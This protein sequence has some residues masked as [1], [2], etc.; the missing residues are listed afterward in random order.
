[1]EPYHFAYSCPYRRIFIQSFRVLKKALRFFDYDNW[2]FRE[3][4][5][6]LITENGKYNHRIFVEA[7]SWE[8]ALYVIAFELSIS[9]KKENVFIVTDGKV[10]S[11]E[12]YPFDDN[13]IYVLDYDISENSIPDDFP[14]LLIIPKSKFMRGG[15]RS[16]ETVS[17]PPRSTRNLITALQNSGVGEARELIRKN[18]QSFESL[19]NYFCREFEYIDLFK[20]T[21]LDEL[22]TVS[23]LSLFNSFEYK[24]FQFVADFLGTSVGKLN[25]ILLKYTIGKDKFLEI[26]K[27]FN[28]SRNLIE[29]V[30]VVQNPI[31]LNLW[32]LSIADEATIDS[33]YDFSVKLLNIFPDRETCHLFGETECSNS[34]IKGILYTWI[35]L[36]EIEDYYIYRKCESFVEA[37]IN[38]PKLNVSY[39]LK[40]LTRIN[41]RCAYSI[42]VT[43]IKSRTDLSDPQEIRYIWF[44]WKDSLQLIADYFDTKILFSL[45]DDVLPI[46]QEKNCQGLLLSFFIDELDPWRDVTLLKLEDISAFLTIHDNDKNI[47]DMAVEFLPNFYRG[48]YSAKPS[49]GIEYDGI[50]PKYYRLEDRER[51]C[52]VSAYVQ[53]AASYRNKTYSDL[54]KIFYRILSFDTSKFDLLFQNFEL[55]SDEEKIQIEI[56][57]REC[58]FLA[59]SRKQNELAKKLFEFLSSIKYEKDNNKYVWLFSYSACSVPFSISTFSKCLTK[60]EQR[61]GEI[62]KY[63]NHEFRP[64]I[65]IDVLESKIAK[66]VEAII[67]LYL[68][69]TNNKYCKDFLLAL[70]KNTSES[71]LY[72]KSVIDHDKD[73]L[74]R[75][76]FDLESQKQTPY[77]Q[78]GYAAV[79]SF[80]PYAE[81]KAYLE[82]IEDLLIK[83]IYYNL[84][85]VNQI[86]N[87][88]LTEN[89]LLDVIDKILIAGFRRIA[90]ACIIS[91][92]NLFSSEQIIHILKKIKESGDENTKYSLTYFTDKDSAVAKIRQYASQHP[93]VQNDVLDIE[94]WYL[95]PEKVFMVDSFNTFYINQNPKYFKELLL[96]YDDS[97]LFRL[98]MN[99][100]CIL[101]GNYLLWIQSVESLLKEQLQISKL[102]S[103]VCYWLYYGPKKAGFKY[104][105][106]DE[107][108]SVLENYSDELRHYFTMELINRENGHVYDDAGSFLMEK[109]KTLKEEALKIENVYPKLANSLEYASQR[110]SNM[111]DEERNRDRYE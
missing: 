69:Y 91:N 28:S 71:Y 102:Y 104:V 80:L 41:Y 95:K 77:Y 92:S 76:L 82:R 63:L 98:F 75:M 9:T 73:V 11:L 58:I 68:E 6:A 60:V 40:L 48:G 81:A 13:K 47:F 18:G 83:K 15:N 10:L 88:N 30:N 94:F 87:G 107:I 14:G 33:F 93:E 32:K 19:K 27:N 85:R 34:L 64:E 24:D 22:E 90:I 78:Y 26:K 43:Q 17:L 45:W 61:V 1:M 46:L 111:A 105:P 108:A 8:E 101:I 72:I 5:K 106:N 65:L 56:K 57:I 55:F 4:F 59:K 31:S 2:D 89:E 109:A 25:L 54:L 96:E 86:N 37:V 38:S 97:H 7:T 84:I 29:K 66:D 52:L 44:R 74:P 70:N 79:L 99:E 62:K 42:F 35:K 67:Y 39:Y 50:S 3:R 36:S 23:K 21:S 49:T 53:Y 103:Y 16:E 110:Y 20:S 51:E 12:K 100:C